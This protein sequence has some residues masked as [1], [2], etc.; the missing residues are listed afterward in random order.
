MTSFIFDK[1]PDKSTPDMIRSILT[2]TSAF[3]DQEIDVAL[4]LVMENLDK[5]S[6]KS[7]YHF[8]LARKDSGPMAG[9]TCFGPIPCTESGY[10][11]YWIAVHRDFQ[12]KGLGKRLYLETEKE[13]IAGSGTRILAETS[14]RKTYVQARNFYLSQ[15]FTKV[16]R[17]KD[18]YA[19]GDDKIIYEKVLSDR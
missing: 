18:F 11:L 12:G 10:D 17:L 16:C 9:F 7:G 14:S 5:G 2:S 6:Q 1:E 4:E 3:S 13:I 8:L 19:P 15:G